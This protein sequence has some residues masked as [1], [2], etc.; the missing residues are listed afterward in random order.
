MNKGIKHIIFNCISTFLLVFWIYVS[1]DKFMGLHAFQNALLRQPF[2]D[3]WADILYWLLPLSEMIIGLLFIGRYRRAGYVLSATLLLV[4]SLYIG[5]G[6]AGLYTERPCGC[7]SVFSM[8]SWKWHLVVNLF[9]LALSILGWYWDRSSSV[10][11]KSDPHPRWTKQFTL[12]IDLL[13][14]PIYNFYRRPRKM[15]PKKFAVFPGRPVASNLDY[16]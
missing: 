9:L 6:L 3:W 1:V 15:F 2:P 7:A 4:F 13:F 14:I 10:G 12:L 16:V 5:L 11:R 8:L